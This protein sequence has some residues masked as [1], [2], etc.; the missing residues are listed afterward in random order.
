MFD[1][2]R[3]IYFLCQSQFFFS[4]MICNINEKEGFNF[5]MLFFLLLRSVCKQMDQ[6]SH[7]IT[8]FVHLQKSTKQKV[9]RAFGGWVIL[10]V[11][12]THRIINSTVYTKNILRNKLHVLLLRRPMDCKWKCVNYFTFLKCSV[13]EFVLSQL[14][15]LNKTV[16][17]K[18]QYIM[19]C[20]YIFVIVNCL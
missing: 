16:L 14:I 10:S 20:S 3:Y 7:V 4:L 2:S 5:S 17:I 8:W 11:V 15:T 12:C 6:K 13:D 18:K 19:V 9:W 1:H